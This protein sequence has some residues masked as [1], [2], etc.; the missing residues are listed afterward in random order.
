MVDNLFGNES[1][2]KNQNLET[3]GQRNEK[4]KEKQGRS[5]DIG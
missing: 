5:T 4:E 3:S 2:Q 1:N